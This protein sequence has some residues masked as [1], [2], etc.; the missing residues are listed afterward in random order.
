MAGARPPVRNLGALWTLLEHMRIEEPG[1]SRSFEQALAEE[2]GWSPGFA[3]AVSREY[4]RFLY[5]AAA[6]DEP[7]TPSIAV[8]KAWH[9]HLTYT[10]HYWDVLC[11]D[12]LGKPLHHEPGLG[13]A[14]E[15]GRFQRQYEATLM[16]YAATF[17]FA[18][19]PEIW[20]WREPSAVP[21]AE[22]HRPVNAQSGGGADCSTLPV[23]DSGGGEAS[24]GGGGCGGGCG[25]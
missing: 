23:I 14:D 24:C 19:P 7:V 18:P 4:R 6:S 20:P 11:R 21:G 13:G 25:S 10:R 12:I 3:E 17:G 9:L 15:D 2:Q 16:L 1:A 22:P 5:L 8:D